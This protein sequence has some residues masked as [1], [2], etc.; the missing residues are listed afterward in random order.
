MNRADFL[1]YRQIHLDFHTS[2]AIEGIGADFDPDEFAATLAKAHVNSI[3][4]FA[5]CHHGW[6]YYQSQAN[7]ERIHPHLARPNLLKEQIEA[8][9]ARG[10]RA[11]IYT[12]IQWDHF[13]AREHVDWLLTE[14]DGR[15]TGTPPF[16]AGF[17]RY[18]NVNSPYIH[19]L[20]EHVREIFDLMPVDGFFFDIVQ[21]IPSS[22][23]YT[24]DG[25]RAAGL[26]PASAAARSQVCAG[27]VEPVQARVQPVRLGHQP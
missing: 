19:F 14:P 8:C 23:P 3:T 15:I 20:R 17:Y 6:I 25:M 18:M 16:E 21:P 24:Q 2:E 26:N 9:H 12:T 11:P 27:F 7:P 13:T 4:V 22:D 1:P 10:I 5:R